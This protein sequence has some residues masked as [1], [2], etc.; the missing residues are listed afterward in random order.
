[1]ES[2]CPIC[3]NSIIKHELERHV[4]S[5]LDEQELKKAKD[6]ELNSKHYDETQVH[7]I[8]KS[9][10][11]T[12]N[13]FKVLGLR[14]DSSNSKKRSQ[15]IKKNVKQ[16]PTLTSV[17]IAEKRLKQIENDINKRETVEN[18][19]TLD[20]KE[21]DVNT[22]YKDSDTNNTAKNRS[23]SE[24]ER[25]NLNEP[26]RPQVDE[27]RESEYLK[28]SKELARLKRESTIPLAQRVRPKNLDDFYGQEHL[29]GKNALLRNMIESGNIPSL[30]LWGLPGVGKTTLARIISSNSNY[31][32]TEVSGS[33]GNAKKLR[34]VFASAENNKKLSGTKTILFLDEIHRFNKAAQD[35]LLPVIEKGTLTVIGAT[36]ENPSFSLNSALLSRMHTFL[37]EP[38][39]E[40]DISRIL[41]KGLY[42]VNKTRKYIHG[43]HPIVLKRD[44]ADYIAALT[45]GDSRAALNIL[46][47]LNAYLSHSQFSRFSSYEESEQK[48]KA[49]ETGVIIVTK[50][51]LRPLLSTR[52]FLLIYDRKGDMHYDTISAFHKSVRGSDANAA[53]FYLSK[54]LAGG[55]DPLFI[56]R[57]MIV[58]A[59]E[60]IG[61]RD[62]SALPFAV[63]TKDALEFIGMPEGEIVL[64]HCAVK[65]ARAPKSTKAYR[66]LHTA[67]TLIKEQ[68]EVKA[69]PIPMHLRNAPTKLMKELGYGETY[70]YNPDFKLGKVKQKYLPPEIEGTN[71]VDDIHLGTTV[72][73]ELDLSEIKKEIDNDEDYTRFKLYKK[74]KF[75]DLYEENKSK[76][77]SLKSIK[78]DRR[79]VDNTEKRK[80]TDNFT[81]NYS[82][83][84]FLSKED[85]P[86]YFDGEENDQYSDDPDCTNNFDSPYDEFHSSEMQPSYLED[87]CNDTYVPQ[88]PFSLEK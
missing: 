35:L 42:L 18:K 38:L 60:D 36:T 15:E 77:A 71:F 52:N 76:R 28:R 55:E 5:C 6:N 11:K 45:T 31:I 49:S 81:P 46:E 87:A 69:L 85:Q 14:M 61:L 4:N 63:A 79:V 27:R 34:E 22:V 40:N 1:M 30:V 86:H 44:A 29:L 88:H 20:R 23:L 39:S 70:K 17:L 3:S 74:K 82:Y 51:S 65:L 68:P 16:K 10:K 7:D 13:A 9:D 56:A 58:I 8:I 75:S 21:L 54:M 19:I 57:R 25:L 50:E 48:L 12:T 43:L 2:V 67:Q 59:S 72:D 62:S 41:F 83:D 80:N 66:A 24:T 64:A 32:F 73:K 37:M 84:E 26:P 47:S 33:E 78:L 53:I